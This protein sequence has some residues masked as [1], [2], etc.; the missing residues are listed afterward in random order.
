MPAQRISR[1]IERPLELVFIEWSMLLVESCS[2]VDRVL[3][4]EEFLRLQLIGAEAIVTELVTSLPKRKG[5]HLLTIC[6]F[7]LGTAGVLRRF[8]CKTVEVGA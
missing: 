1:V 3:V 2:F 6:I 4:V 5:L 7:N 8:G